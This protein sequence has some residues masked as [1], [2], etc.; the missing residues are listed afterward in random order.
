MWVLALGLGMF[1]CYF[2][3]KMVLI[4]YCFLE[5][6][7]GLIWLIGKTKVVKNGF[8]QDRESTSVRIN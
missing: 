5:N 8:D 3:L 1:V 4:L 2:S 6:V 7:F